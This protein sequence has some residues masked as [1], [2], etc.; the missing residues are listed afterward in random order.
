MVLHPLH[1]L[2]VLGHLKITS[3][4]AFKKF[5]EIILVEKSQATTIVVGW[6]TQGRSQKVDLT[7][8]LPFR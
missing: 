5:Q 2:P 4:K 8:T 6:K 7:R 1:I 3:H